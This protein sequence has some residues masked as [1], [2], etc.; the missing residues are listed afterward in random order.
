[1]SVLKI[2]GLNKYYGKVHALKDINIEISPGIFG[3]LGPNGAGKT[4]LMRIL[5]T[6][7]KPSSGNI[8]FGEI[9]WR[10]EEN[11][12]E[13]VG[14][15]PQKF[16]IYK[17]LTVLETLDHIAILKG[18]ENRRKEQVKEVI[19]KVNLKE[20]ANKKIGQLSGGMVRRV[21]IA[22]AIL[23]EPPIIIVD[24]PTSGLDPEER[25]RF[26]NLITTLNKNS[27]IL[28]STHIVDDIKS[29]CKEAAILNEGKVAACGSIDNLVANT[30]GK[31]WEMIIPFGSDEAELVKYEVVRR[32]SEDKGIR[33]RILS[34]KEVPGATQAIPELE[35][36]Y[37]CA[38]KGI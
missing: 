33:I 36:A 3:L 11:V 6:L 21:G 1:M 10:E 8:S 4:T 35:D 22:Q 32:T 28:L 15:L 37:L 26:R 38:T 24:E 5:S 7:Y 23:G 13:I 29:I 19:E 20:K 27:I 9:N 18:I 12:R 31:V 34:T 25:V 17:S 2:E 30:K 16:S 14:Y